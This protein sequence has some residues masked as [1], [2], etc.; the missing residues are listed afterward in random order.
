MVFLIVRKH[1]LQCIKRRVGEI[2]SKSNPA[3]LYTVFW[4]GKGYGDVLIRFPS[5]NNNES[6]NHFSPKFDAVV[7]VCTNWEWLSVTSKCHSHT[8]VFILWVEFYLR[9]F[10]FVLIWWGKLLIFFTN[11]LINLK[12]FLSSFILGS[13]KLHFIKMMNTMH[14]D[15]LTVV[16]SQIPQ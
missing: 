14:N 5:E 15:L 11:F 2:K 4:K 16:L 6:R 3:R 8:G 7:T 1:P 9:N 13:H 12:Q 10:I